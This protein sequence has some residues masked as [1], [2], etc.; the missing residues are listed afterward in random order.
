MNAGS[1]M[2]SP[3]MV[4]CTLHI[5]ANKRKRLRAS[6]RIRAR[7]RIY[8]HAPIHP[9]PWGICV[10]VYLSVHIYAY[11]RIYM[12][13]RIHS[14]GSHTVTHTHALTRAHAHTRTTCIGKRRTHA[15]LDASVVYPATPDVTLYIYGTHL[16]IH[17]VY[18]Y[19]RVSTSYPGVVDVCQGHGH[20]SNR[21]TRNRL[22]MCRCMRGGLYVS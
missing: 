10:C 8:V 7:G 19:A 3:H 11:V 6:P 12:R 18:S 14:P 5:C 22:Y 21:G 15:V 13:T 2:T 1:H 16:R 4:V 9:F 20:V 17:L